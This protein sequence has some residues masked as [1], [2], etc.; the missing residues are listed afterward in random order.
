MAITIAGIKA[1]P[2]VGSF[3]SRIF[4]KPCDPNAF[5]KFIEHC[6]TPGAR[7]YRTY[8]Q[9][10]CIQKFI[11]KQ[12]MTAK[13]KSQCSKLVLHE[14]RNWAKSQKRNI[15]GHLANIRVVAEAKPKPVEVH[16]VSA[17]SLQ[18]G[19]TATIKKSGSIT[20]T[21]PA[22][23]SKIPIWVLVGIGALFILPQLL[24]MGES[25]EQIRTR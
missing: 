9:L 19:Q 12:P 10:P 22:G 7:Y 6:C 20:E 17:S 2:V 23:I 15:Q 14:T 25:K 24:K 21:I 16:T 8:S 3:V 13:E 11:H 4:K 1:V 5:K 18:L